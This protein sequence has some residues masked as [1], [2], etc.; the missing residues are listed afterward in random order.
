MHTPFQ[1]FL[2]TDSAW[3][4]RAWVFFCCTLVFCTMEAVPRWT[5]PDLHLNWPPWIYY[6]INSICG[7]VAGPFVTWYRLPG[8]LAGALAG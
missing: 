6:A 8:L 4:W 3:P 7:A 5:H 1:R 2:R